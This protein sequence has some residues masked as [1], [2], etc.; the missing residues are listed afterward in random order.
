MVR[1]IGVTRFSVLAPKGS[2]LRI[3]TGKSREQY[4][5]ELFDDARLADRFEVFGNVSAPIMQAMAA[6]YQYT[7]LVQYSPE[8]PIKWRNRLFEIAESYPVIK[9]VEVKNKDIVDSVID[10]VRTWPKD[11]RDVFVWFRIDDDDVLAL[12]Y[13]DSLSKYATHEN[14]G[15]AICFNQVVSAMFDGSTFGDVRSVYSPFN[16]QGAAFI[17]RANLNLASIE[18]PKMLPHHLVHK[19][20]PTLVLPEEPH[21]LWTRHALQDTAV[22]NAKVGGKIANLQADLGKSPHY[23][24]DSLVRKFPTLQQYLHPCKDAQVTSVTLSPGKW[25]D[26]ALAPAIEGQTYRIDISLDV[27]GSPDTHTTLTFKYSDED[28][29]H[30]HFPRT[31]ERGD[32]RRIYPDKYGH[33]TIYI[34]AIPSSTPNQLRILTDPPG[35]KVNSANIS[36]SLEPGKC[37]D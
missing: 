26:I 20:L 32:Y 8:L 11:F 35:N 23:P 19:H 18:S 14:V 7:H 2:G 5:A 17:C 15:T 10:E 3:V 37:H 28:K 24:E 34:P 13:L 12:D 1:F 27:V 22:G 25:K 29:A 33:A 31:A 9:P 6:Q 36:I 16:S 30:G 4:A 21:A